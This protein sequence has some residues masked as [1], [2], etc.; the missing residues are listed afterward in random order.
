[1]ILLAL[2]LNACAGLETT[3]HLEVTEY[4]LEKSRITGFGGQWHYSQERVVGPDSEKF[5]SCDDDF[6]KSGR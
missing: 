1:L 6:Q 5:W 2:W 3:H 4:F